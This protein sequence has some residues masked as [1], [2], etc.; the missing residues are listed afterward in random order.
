MEKG[1]TVLK[2]KRKDFRS[3]DQSKKGKTDFAAAGKAAEA[4]AQSYNDIVGG[5]RHRP[6]GAAAQKG[7]KTMLAAVAEEKKIIVVIIGGKQYI[8]R[9]LIMGLTMAPTQLAEIAKK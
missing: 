9:Q 8:F 7:R 4:T 6:F 3:G 2:G 1:K 5:K